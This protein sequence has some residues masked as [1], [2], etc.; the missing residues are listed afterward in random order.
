MTKKITLQDIATQLGYSKNTI[1][2]ALRNNSQIPAQTRDK[3]QRYAKEIG[4][5]A[6]PIVSQLMTEL[7]SYQSPKFQAKLALLNANENPKAFKQHPTIPSYVEGCLR[8]ARQLGY[9]FDTF[10]INEAKENTSRFMQILKARNIRGII[11]VGLM[12]ENQL[13]S[14]LISAWESFP[15]VVTGVRTRNPTLSFACVDHHMLTLRS[16][17]RLHERGYRRPALILDDAIDKLVERRFSAGYLIAQSILKK[18]DRLPPFMDY[19]KAKQNPRRFKEWIAAKKP[20]AVLS[21][22]H[23]VFEWLVEMGLGIP[24]D[25]GFAQLECRPAQTQFSGMDQHNDIAG[26]AAVDMLISQIHNNESGIQKSPRSIL[27]GATWLDGKTI[28]A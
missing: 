6:N 5:Q 2:L 17:E 1:S 28:R 8:R 23:S 9:S 24:E 25:I 13:P 15:T 18:K 11:I 20:D 19:R 7:R 26:E 14:Q 27:I 10:W 3:I 4:Y 12:G 16:I 22:Y 21:L